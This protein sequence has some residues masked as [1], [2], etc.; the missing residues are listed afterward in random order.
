MVRILASV[1]ILFSVAMTGCQKENNAK[2]VVSEE[3]NSTNSNLRGE[4]DKAPEFTLLD[5]QGNNVSLSDF[6]GK[7][8][9]VDFWATWCPPCRRGI[10]DLIDLQNQ[11]KNK[12]A[13]I[14]ISV[15][16]ENTKAGV[17]DFIDKMGINYPVVYFNDKV[18]NDYGGIE[19]IPTTFIIDKQG[20]IIKKLVGLY[21][22]TEIEKQLNDL[23]KES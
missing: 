7:V 20:N 2:P 12:V 11:Y 1:L 18:I 10:P 5:T 9:I 14:G 21:P 13:V 22:K 19:A 16:R 3:N 4:T 8:V 6:K 23:I 15:D 17:P